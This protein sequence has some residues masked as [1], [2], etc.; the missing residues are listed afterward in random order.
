MLPLLGTIVGAL[1]AAAG[2]DEPQLLSVYAYGAVG[3]GVA[4]DTAAIQRTIEA[5]LAAK[6]VA[7][8]PGNGTYML[9]AGLKFVGH[10]YDGVRMQFDGPFTLIN[11]SLWPVC[12]SPGWCKPTSREPVC[13]D[14]CGPLIEVN[15][16]DGFEL[17]SQ[18]A[19]GLYG[20]N[21][22]NKGNTPAGTHKAP[23]RPIA[24]SVSNSTCVAR[25][26]A[27]PPACCSLRC[28]PAFLLSAALQCWN[29]H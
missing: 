16:V 28:H 13:P 26:T 1:L 22:S 25:L 27:D 4:N 24:I 10:N 23:R 9:G 2:V 18:G 19:G 7:W 3:D 21:Y 12:P 17:I 29:S 20:T 5:S 11:D 15:N 14:G 8:A 6:A